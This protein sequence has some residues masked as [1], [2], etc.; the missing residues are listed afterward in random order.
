MLTVVF[1]AIILAAVC[2]ETGLCCQRRAATDILKL[3]IS[4]KEAATYMNILHITY[5]CIL[6]YSD[7]HTV[8]V[9]IKMQACLA[10]GLVI[11]FNRHYSNAL[12]SQ[13]HDINDTT[14]RLC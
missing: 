4:Q 14:I 5:Y 7:L 3:C 1:Y 13:A 12:L 2:V 11:R 8:D 9:M 6:L 10:C